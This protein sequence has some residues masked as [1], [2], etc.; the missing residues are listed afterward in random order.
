[1][2]LAAVAL[3]TVLLPGVMAAQTPQPEG[4]TTDA[5][6]VAIAAAAKSAQ[7]GDPPATLRFANR[8]IVEFRATVVSRP[9]AVRAAAA[10]DTLSRFLE[11][12][13]DGEVATRTY[14][15]GVLVTLG[16]R[17]VFVLFESDVDALSG[18][19]LDTKVQEAAAHLATAYRE[20]GELRSP[21]RLLPGIL[22]AIA[23]TVLYG[24]LLW[25]LVRL[26]KRVAAAASRATERRLRELP[27]G[28]VMV[29]A[30][31]PILVHRLVTLLS[32]GLAL[33]F[34]YSWL[35][36]VLRRFP[37]TRPWGE[38]LR[39]SLFS[40]V[41]SGTRGFV[42][43]LPNLLTILVIVVITRF[44]IRLVTFAFRTVE[45]GRVSMPGV[46]PETAQP[47]RRIT[48]LL[49][50]VFALVLSYD[51]LPGAKSDAF[52]G[53]SVFIGL[54]ISLGSSGIMNQVMSGLMVTYSR[55]LRVGDFVRIADVEGTVT[56]LG[57]LSTK[58]R[59]PRNEEITLPN[60][61]VVSHAATN[62]TRHA[63]DGVM[64]PSSVTIGYDVPW[65][66]VQALLLMAAERTP[67]VRRV[68]APVVLQTALG[69][70]AVQ[71]T[72]LVCLDQPQRRLP[73]L[74]ALH[75]NIQDAF[76]EYGVQIMSPSY[77]ADPSERK[78]VPPSQW[79][80]APAADPSAQA[81]PVAIAGV[82]QGPARAG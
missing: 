65:R 47:T 44:A 4:T 70:F 2:A 37:Y 72:V 10:S 61:L 34:T 16:G 51:L 38:S 19:R 56:Q 55:A 42:D 3:S 60:A 8:A 75:A 73:T 35:A 76:N 30:R 78:T 24:L 69:D 41:A 40:A 7:T 81:A 58:I 15:G 1:M 62:F 6:A 64:A 66:Q 31:A 48:V 25:M 20:A 22:V 54:I 63:D 21:R 13:P 18:E 80:A 77:E 74:N 14:D 43:L 49:L 46:Y 45:E 23:A 26:D 57:T 71:Y 67:G 52:K 79:Y 5:V 28:E 68:P 50:C 82:P 36:I 29:V 53:V 27:G 9:P 33:F 11:Q 39:S 59:T 32:I 17:P 12:M